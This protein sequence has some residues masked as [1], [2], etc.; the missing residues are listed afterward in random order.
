MKSRFY[1]FQAHFITIYVIH[2]EQ[3]VGQIFFW[4]VFLSRV[5][6]ILKKTTKKIFFFG[7]FSFFQTKKMKK[8]DVLLYKWKLYRE[9]K[10]VRRFFSNCG[11]KRDTKVQAYFRCFNETTQKQKKLRK[12]CRYTTCYHNKYTTYKQ[13]QPQHGTNNRT[14]LN[15]QLP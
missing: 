2:V 13:P 6:F 7:F 4:F 5:F 11:T 3:L 9:R 12:F 14:Q 8:N 15:S 10:S 1:T